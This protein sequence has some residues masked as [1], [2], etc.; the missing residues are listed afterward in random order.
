MTAVWILVV[1]F[2]VAYTAIGA[3]AAWDIWTDDFNPYSEPVPRP[4]RRAG[5]RR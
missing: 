5:F 1:V 3:L 4:E 2:G